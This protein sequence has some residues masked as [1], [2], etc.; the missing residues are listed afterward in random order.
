MLATHE[1]IQESSQAQ[2]LFEALPHWLSHVPLY[3]EAGALV[4]G[5]LKEGAGDLL[6]LLP[7]I[8]K[9]HL[10]E[11]F[12]GNF[13]GARG[14]LDGLLDAQLVELEHTSGTSEERMPLLLG[15][16]WWA[17][18]EARALRL[19][20]LV[21][22]VLDE[23]PGAHRVTIASPVCNN[24][25][26]YTGVPSA[27]ERTVGTTLFVN[28]SRFPFLWSEADLARMASEA[29]EWKPEFLDVDPVYGAVFARYCKRR[30]IRLPTLRF[31]VSSYEFVSRIHRRALE[32][33]FG[34]PVLNL[35]GST[36]TGHLLMENGVGQL[37]PSLETAV[38]EVIN[39]DANGVGELVVTTLTNEYM[40]L[41]RYQIGDLV[42]K[43]ERPYRTTYVL[44]GR[45][46]DALSLPGGGRVTLWQL[47]RC[48]EGIPGILHYQLRQEGV[49]G[50]QLLLVPEGGDEE[51][52][53]LPELRERL[54]DLAGAGCD[55]TIK[56]TT[57][58][59]PEPSGKF[60]LSHTVP[61]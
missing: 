14:D 12:P 10:R 2:R 61:V 44:H 58:L 42:E 3:R 60:R 38:L 36:E 8:S 4:R 54:T 1:F 45:A 48:F 5:S 24:D 33:A 6:S 28:L 32:R 26:C 47:D 59:L 17:E 11:G 51:V 43:I 13:L 53:N 25:V 20:P 49:A 9:R 37:V 29:A 30:G 16:G 40:P 39:E 15:C 19:N 27:E 41:I 56:T 34:V 22:R 23:S 7:L 46:D 52:L 18:Q 35:Y 31:I 21:A 55:L 57:A 50:W